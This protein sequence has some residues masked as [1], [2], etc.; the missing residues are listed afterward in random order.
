MTDIKK[1][2]EAVKR[3]VVDLISE[4]ELIQKFKKGKPLRIKLGMDPTAPDIHL[5]HSVVL[6]KMREFQNLGHKAVLIIGDYTARV[7]DPSGTDKTRPMLSGEEIDK[8]A[9][10]YLD[11]AGKILDLSPEKFEMRKNSE[12]LSKMNFAEVI[13]LASN[14][15]VARM[16]E[17][18][19]FDKRFKAGIPIGTHEFLYPLMQGYDSFKVAADVELGGTDQTFNNLVGRDIQR[20]NG[21]EQQVVIVMPLL[22][23]LDGT[24]K[25]SKSKGNYI[26][27]TES[28][29]E[30]FGKVMSV[31][32]ELM[33][34]YYELL[35][36]KTLKEIINLKK[37]VAEGRAH[38]KV[39]KVELAKEIIAQFYNSSEAE[40]SEKEFEKIFSKK[41][42]PSEI[43]EVVIKKGNNYLLVD[44]L[45]TLNMVSSK[46]E[47]RRMIK[48]SG[49]SVNEK[50]I[51]DIDETIEGAGEVV[52][53][54]GKRKFK[55]V[56]FK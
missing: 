50:K 10:T 13:K 2:L 16:L 14:M 7:G 53:R 24:E 20:A 55:K 31:S 18:D 37:E 47:A 23:G 28:A 9:Q 4:D 54:V 5:G 19:S 8:N 22:V 43:E 6:H 35:S 39:A 3:G 52:L 49:I 33:W 34:N 45:L 38:P 25:M 30:I 11:Q 15:T 56:L 1:Q 40:K 27:V 42:M 51:S 46:G 17:R 29:Q 32:D 21:M 26:G 48:Q 44:L 12:W 36:S 41:E